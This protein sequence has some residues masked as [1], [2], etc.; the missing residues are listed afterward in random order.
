MRSGRMENTKLK[1]G[2][3]LIVMGLL[4]AC[5][6]SKD[7]GGGPV[8]PAPVVTEAQKECMKNQLVTVLPWGPYDAVK[9]YRACGGPDDSKVF[10]AL[11]EELFVV[12]EG[13]SWRLR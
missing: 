1:A 3:V 13:K 12:D 2:S 7:D 10:A 9:V 4:M 6:K 11:A 5:E 8:D